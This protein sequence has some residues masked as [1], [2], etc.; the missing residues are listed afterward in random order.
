VVAGILY[1]MTLFGVGV[2]VGG[3]AL[4]ASAALR[5]LVGWQRSRSAGL[6]GFLG[7]LRAWTRSGSIPPTAQAL[8]EADTAP[9]PVAPL[10]AICDDT[11]LLSHVVPEPLRYVEVAASHHLGGS[12]DLDGW[13]RED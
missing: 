1:W 12:T 2:G 10:G 5:L 3:L 9:Q 8:A 6:G 4:M 7:G 11:V 13:L